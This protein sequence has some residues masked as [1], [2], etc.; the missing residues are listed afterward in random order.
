MSGLFFRISA[1]IFFLVSG[2]T[3][4]WLFDESV[5]EITA[6][7]NA[8]IVDVQ[9]PFKNTSGKAIRFTNF[10]VSCS[11]S[12][13]TTSPQKFKEGEWIPTGGAGFLTLSVEIGLRTGAVKQHVLVSLSQEGG[14]TKTV[15]VNTL[16]HVPK[17]INIEPATLKWKVGEA[18]TPK[19][20]T[21]QILPGKEIT[22]TGLKGSD[23]NARLIEVT[24]QGQY[25]IEIT[26]KSTAQSTFAIF[27]IQTTS[28][29]PSY[30]GLRC[31]GLVTSR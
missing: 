6:R 26:P 18:P 21:I 29:H 12:S 23:M 1:M 7:E 25:E 11:C 13:L 9:I 17:L 4:A 24:A 16:I 14:A 20:L 8:K 3:H 5:Y 2:L 10:Q 30:Q 28:K 31:Y 22:I 19:R 27:D 15:K